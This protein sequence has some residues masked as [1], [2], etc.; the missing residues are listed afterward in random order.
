MCVSEGRLVS[1]RHG[2]PLD[3]YGRA[4]GSSFQLT[5]ACLLPWQMT[6]WHDGPGGFPAAVGTGQWALYSWA[7]VSA[8]TQ[9]QGMKHAEVAD[10]YHRDLA[11]ADHLVRA[12]QLLH[13]DERADMAR[14]ATA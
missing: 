8:W 5:E 9:T 2:E 1:P 10:D 7:E 13:R 6:G 12:R 3:V 14:L 11:A 4:F